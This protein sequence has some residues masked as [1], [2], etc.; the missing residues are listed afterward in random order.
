MANGVILYE[1]PSELDGSPIVV[2]ATFGSK[3]RKTGKGRKNLIQTWIMRQ[4]VA[5]W[6]AKTQDLD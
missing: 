5:P 1:G 6:D 4:D 2:I 3:N